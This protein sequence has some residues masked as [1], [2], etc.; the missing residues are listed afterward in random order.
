M[1]SFDLKGMK[2][3]GPIWVKTWSLFPENRLLCGLCKCFVHEIIKEMVVLDLKGLK[4][5]NNLWHFVM[6]DSVHIL[7]TQ[8]FK[9]SRAREIANQA[10]RPSH[11]LTTM[12]SEHSR[13]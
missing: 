9:F 7:C 6:E 2:I 3:F 12:H 4:L 11:Q 1:G 8:N 10:P 13:E 5:K